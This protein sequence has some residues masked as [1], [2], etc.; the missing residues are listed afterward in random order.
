M[1]MAQPILSSTLASWKFIFTPHNCIDSQIQT[2]ASSHH[3]RTAL[4]CGSRTSHTTTYT[5]KPQQRVPLDHQSQPQQSTP[6]TTHSPFELCRLP[7]QLNRTPH[8]AP[9][10]HLPVEHRHQGPIVAFQHF[11]DRLVDAFVAVVAGVASWRCRHRHT[12]RVSHTGQ[13]RAASG[14]S[15]GATAREGGDCDV[16]VA[17][18][19]HAV[20]GR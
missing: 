3:L 20:S 4:I 9:C 2:A 1:C 18:N 17:H 5:A 11:G 6:Q 7:A 13:R 14:D 16:A 15:G 19:R 8:N 12:I 10:Q